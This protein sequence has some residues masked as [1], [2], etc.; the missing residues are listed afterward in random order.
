METLGQVV[1]VT[2]AAGTVSGIAESV[3]EHGALFIREGD[4]G[5]QRVIVGDALS[6]A[7]R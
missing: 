1:A 5:L 3:D 6:S 7:R 4:G 2:S